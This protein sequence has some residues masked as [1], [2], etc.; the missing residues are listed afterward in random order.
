MFVPRGSGAFGG[1]FAGW[2][3][4]A[5][6]V[7]DGVDQAFLAKLADRLADGVAGDAELLNQPH[8]GDEVLWRV[9]AAADACA[10]DVGD[11][12]PAGAVRLELDHRVKGRKGLLRVFTR[13]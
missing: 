3:D 8:F 13:L 10:K 6:E 4:E 5:A 9:F 11:L 2:A 7:G 1:D 12:L